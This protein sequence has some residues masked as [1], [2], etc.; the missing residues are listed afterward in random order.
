MFL[1]KPGRYTEQ[2]ERKI[3][4]RGLLDWLLPIWTLPLVCEIHDKFQVVYK[5]LKPNWVNFKVAKITFTPGKSQKWENGKFTISSIKFHVR[6]GTQKNN[7][8]SF[9]FQKSQPYLTKLLQR[10]QS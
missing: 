2:E 9:I 3:F 6:K 7:C 4:Q 5:E 8:K 1:Y 10:P